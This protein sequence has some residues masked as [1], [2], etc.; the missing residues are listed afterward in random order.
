M[1]K[2]VRD[3]WNES[4]FRSSAGPQIEGLKLETRWPARD[5]RALIDKETLARQAAPAKKQER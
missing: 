3:R 5:L 1:A 2:E 4:L